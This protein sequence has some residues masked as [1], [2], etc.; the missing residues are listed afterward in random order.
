MKKKYIKYSAEMLEAID[1]DITDEPNF[2]TYLQN[3][4]KSYLFN[5]QSFLE[6]GSGTSDIAYA[7]SEI[8]QA[9]LYL[10]NLLLPKYK[11][12]KVLEEI[13]RS[14]EIVFNK[15]EEKVTNTYF[16]PVKDGNQN[17]VRNNGSITASAEDN[18]V[19][20]ETIKG[21]SEKLVEFYDLTRN[22]IEK[23]FIDFINIMV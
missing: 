11:E 7:L 17:E 8:K 10:S 2:D 18:T 14:T 1:F 21:E 16:E 6:V 23:V 15:G 5:K 9:Y 22:N 13:K 20:T 3:E 4:T 12:I 19:T